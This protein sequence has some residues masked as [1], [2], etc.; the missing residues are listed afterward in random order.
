M[1]RESH[2]A[3]CVNL[4][5][6]SSYAMIRGMLTPEDLVRLAVADGQTTLA[7]TDYGTTSALVRFQRAAQKAGIRPLFGVDMA[8]DTDVSDP[9]A[10]ALHDKTP[11][12]VVLLCESETGY[13]NM[14]NLVTRAN[15]ENERLGLPRLRESWL[16][17]AAR[18]GLTVLLG[19]THEGL[20]PEVLRREGEAAAQRM[21]AWYRETWGRHVALEVQ[22]VDQDREAEEIAALV[23]ISTATGV[24]LVAT[25]PNLFATRKDFSAHEVRVAAASDR[26]VYDPTRPIAFTREQHFATSAFLEDR[27]AD[28]PVAL[29]N[30][31]ALAAAC[32]FEIGLGQVLMPH[33]PDAPDRA[34]E[35]ALFKRLCVE[36]LQ[37]RLAEDH[38]DPV[39]RARHRPTYEAR[40]T[41]EMAVIERMGFEGYFLV[42][43]DVTQWAARQGIAV[44]VGR[45]SAAGSL[46]AYALGITNIDPLPHNLLFERFLNPERV[47]M[48]DID[49]DLEMARRD[50]VL[51]YIR[52]RYGQVAQIATFSFMGAKSALTQAGKTLDISPMLRLDVSKALDTQ[53]LLEAHAAHQPGLR[54]A[55][56]VDARLRTRYDHEPTVRQM[57]DKAMA[58]ETVPNATSRHAGG[59]VI[60]PG[61]LSDVT[62][63]HVSKGVVTTDYDKDDVE[64]VGLIK[65]DFLGL[66]NLTAVR[67]AREAIQAAAPPGTPPLNLYK[68]PLD[69]PKVYELLSQ[70]DTTG[71][72]QFESQGMRQGLMDLKPETFEDA[73][74]LTALFRPGPLNS[75]MM[76]EFID[77]RHGRSPVVYPHPSLEPI[78]KPTYGTIVYQEQVMQIAQVLAGYSLGQADLLRKAMG[79]KKAEAMEQERQR[80]QDGAVARGVDPEVARNIFNMMAKFAEYGFNKSHAVAYTQVSY[81]TAWLKVHHL[82]EF[83]AALLNTERL[84]GSKTAVTAKI[85]RDAR[86]HGITILPPDLN[87][88]HVQTTVTP[89]GALRLGLST[90]QSVLAGSA[91]MILAI[92]NEGGPF[93]DM[94][95]VF[96]R[97]ARVNKTV[98]EALV[99]AG[100]MDGIEPNRARF[101]ANTKAGVAYGSD[102]LK[103]RTA[104]TDIVAS[105]ESALAPGQHSSPPAGKKK[106][107]RSKGKPPPVVPAWVDA[108]PW[109]ADTQYR[110]EV[111]VLGVGLSVNPLDVRRQ[112]A[113]GLKGCR[114]PGDNVGLAVDDTVDFIGVVSDVRDRPKVTFMNV[115][116]EDGEIDVTVF[117]DL[118]EAARDE[119]Q[120]GR[121]VLIRGRVEHVAAAETAGDDDAGP[122]GADADRET[123]T[124]ARP[125]FQQKTKVLA[126]HV[127]GWD[128]VRA[129]ALES[130]RLSPTPAQMDDLVAVLESHRA[131]PGD[132]EGIPVVWCVADPADPARAWV[133]TAPHRAR[134]DPDLWEAC[135]RILGPDRMTA[136]WRAA[137][138]LPPPPGRRRN[139]PRRV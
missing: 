3:P 130:L 44:G 114:T 26:L 63:L 29:D 128:R 83:Y 55:L 103:H 109:D 100:A 135:E 46:A 94:T 87:A 106:P 6:T 138:R 131:P 96:E 19:G 38:P 70:G 23:R 8:I 84:A 27:F 95:D 12:R 7:L 122:E 56:A 20:I 69:D 9:Q 107:S 89:D 133:G 31:R 48:P 72:F 101:I 52:N 126:T 121:V 30:A 57:I 117:P 33:S 42:V 74:A 97:L 123:E 49:T 35:R 45:G 67:L 86:A 91:Q 99:R 98:I 124:P 25:H 66:K 134:P 64:A 88:S 51:E 4:R 36:G 47:S 53:A 77:R 62:A 111:R 73:V 115:A 113:G 112:A 104:N 5:A 21:T 81:Q 75:G 139:G 2:R 28:L 92:R 16:D 37:R 127:V 71:V 34:S 90:V 93:K 136:T 11:G 105:L 15:L 40:L 54:H 59:V 108:P 82:R 61:R 58:I 41:T 119:C 125:A 78:L 14:L 68:L 18:E 24:P 85:I 129:A 118:R 13:R 120:T 17:A 79:K 60:A 80:F 39:D 65:F 1:T 22:R 116:A 102:R 43:A 132:A 76:K 32:R 50:E 110:E 10:A 137:P